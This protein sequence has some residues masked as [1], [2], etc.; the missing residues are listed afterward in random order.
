MRENDQKMTYSFYEFPDTQ[1][2]IFSV[3]NVDWGVRQ[4]I[5]KL[6]LPNSS[7]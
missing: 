7:M 6:K 5:L 1:Y 2:Q 3:W 4:T